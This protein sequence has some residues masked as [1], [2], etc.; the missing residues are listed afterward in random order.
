MGSVL[1]APLNAYMRAR[2]RLQ[3]RQAKHNALA[4]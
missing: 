3:L 2:L 1:K 4:H